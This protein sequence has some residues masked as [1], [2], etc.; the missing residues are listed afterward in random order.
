MKSSERNREWVKRLPEV[1]G[2]LNNEVTRLTGR[3]PVDAIRDGVVDAKSA[4]RYSRPIG[5][6]EKQLDYSVNM[7]Y[8]YSDGELEGGKKRATDP[9]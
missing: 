8:L 4:T 5:L 7:R 2:A 3:K 1:V 9:N 6:K